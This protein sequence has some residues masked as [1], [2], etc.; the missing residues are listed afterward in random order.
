MKKSLK[1]NI[2]TAAIIML[3]SSTAQA[4]PTLQLYMEG[5]TYDNG[6][7]TWTLSTSGTFK[8]W[9]IGQGGVYDV[10]L[11]AAYTTGEAGAITLTPTTASTLYL[12]SLTS[13]LTT[14]I[15]PI[16]NGF[17]A[18]GT[19]P[20]MG[21]GAPLPTH[22]I[23]GLGTSWAEWL[24]GD[25][26]ATSDKVADMTANPLNWK[27]G[28]L[29]AYDVTTTGFSSIHFDAYGRTVLTNDKC[30]YKDVKA[31]FSHNAEASTIP[32]PEPGTMVLFSFGLLGLIVYGKR[33]MS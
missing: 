24:L 22:G 16:F 4:I 19:T 17:K 7:E 20:V 30:K 29:N 26:L 11:A 31:P 8:L 3:T 12:P 33:R 28:Q 25:F 32:V 18:D 5:A 14:P 15:A 1:L 21:S 10:K 23:Y 13:D 2:L 27:N 9:V 6:S